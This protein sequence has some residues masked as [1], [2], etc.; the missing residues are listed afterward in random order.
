[1][2]IGS[3][4]P[5]IIAVGRLRHKQVDDCSRSDIELQAGLGHMAKAYLKEDKTNQ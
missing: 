1:M 4:T 2:G 5:V 3:G